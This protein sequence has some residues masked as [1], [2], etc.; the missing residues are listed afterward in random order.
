MSTKS[1]GDARFLEVADLI[2][3]RARFNLQCAAEAPLGDERAAHMDVAIEWIDAYSAVVRAAQR[4]DR[5][6]RGPR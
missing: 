3:H 5:A 6:L 4:E 1:L 2:A